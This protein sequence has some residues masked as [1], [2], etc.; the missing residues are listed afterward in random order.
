[1]ED[2]QPADQQLPSSPFAYNN[3]NGASRNDLR[4]INAPEARREE[5]ALGEADRGTQVP[6]ST[7]DTTKPFS[8]GTYHT[9]LNRSEQLNN[10][11]TGDTR[12]N[13]NS[14]SSRKRTRQVCMFACSYHS[15]VLMGYH[16]LLHRAMNA[17]IAPH[18]SGRVI[19][20]DNQSFDLLI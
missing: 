9:E 5:S 1:M 12:S 6:P 11:Q 3:T 15:T 19:G 2:R 18:R 4:E 16:D 7:T 10:G 13:G 8:R 20:H 17:T 14:L